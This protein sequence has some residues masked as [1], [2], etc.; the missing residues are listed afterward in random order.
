VRQQ[1]E[2]VCR[3]EWVLV[4]VVCMWVG[5]EECRF[6]QERV[7]VLGVLVVV[8]QQEQESHECLEVVC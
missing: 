6:V 1:E 5:E 8:V 2:E 7:Q 4:Q 3:F